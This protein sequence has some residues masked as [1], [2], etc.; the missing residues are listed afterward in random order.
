MCSLQISVCKVLILEVLYRSAKAEK[1]AALIVLTAS[2]SV[3]CVSC[4]KGDHKFHYPA[5]LLH[6]VLKWLLAYGLPHHQSF[7]LPFDSCC[8]ASD[9]TANM[10]QTHYIAHAHNSK[11]YI[12]TV[13]IN[14]N[15]KDTATYN[16]L[17]AQSTCYTCLQTL[18]PVTVAVVTTQ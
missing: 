15:A 2:S 5:T 14:R 11:R 9:G 18:T 12:H 13:T 4:S 6:A 10:W 7:P 3:N 8:V 16:T 1:P 17:V